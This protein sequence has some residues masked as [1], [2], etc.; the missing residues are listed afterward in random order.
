MK[1][2]IIVG[3]FVLGVLFSHFFRERK[4]IRNYINKYLIYIGLPLLVFVSFHKIQDMPLGKYVIISLLAGLVMIMGAYLLIRTFAMPGKDKASLLLCS[5][6]GNTAYLGIP[7]LYAIWGDVGSVVA[8]VFTLATMPLRY[9]LG[10]FL[11]HSYTK[12]KNKLKEF[13]KLPFFWV[14]LGAIGLSYVIPLVPKPVEVVASASTALALF[15]VGTS[16]SFS[17]ISWRTVGLTMLKLL[18]IPA[19]CLP[20]FIFT[21][22]KDPIAFIAISMMPSAFINTSLALEF[23][24][25]D[26]LASQ[27]TTIGTSIFMLGIVIL[28]ILL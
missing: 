20:L 24:F 14:L 7:V 22:L 6:Y 26:K 13:F 2:I 9:S 12:R 23:K 11:A 25:N 1:L 28:L 16:M 18:V 19:L 15:I 8:T 17:S 21:G 4:Q 10:L 27:L 5:A 3:F